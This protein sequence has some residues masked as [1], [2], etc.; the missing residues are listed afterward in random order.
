VWKWL[1]G[2]SRNGKAVVQKTMDEVIAMLRLTKRSGEVATVFSILAGAGLI[3][4][5]EADYRARV[6]VLDADLDG[7]PSWVN[8]VLSKLVESRMPGAS[9][10]YMAPKELTKLI[11]SRQVKDCHKKMQYLHNADLVEYTPAS[12]GK[13]TT[14]NAEKDLDSEIN[15]DRLGQKK[16]EEERV[17][18][19]MK[20]FLEK[21]PDEEKHEVINR[22]F[23]TGSIYEQD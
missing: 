19:E 11:G 3:V 2:E 6:R 10:V 7:Q 17:F 21:V 20:Y 13:S 14:V 23:L 12:R 18:G 16:R 5:N 9:S 15:W 22:Y 4:R 8:D 1:K